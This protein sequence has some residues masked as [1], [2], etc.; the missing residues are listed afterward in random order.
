[1][2]YYSN[3]PKP[4]TVI[5][6]AKSIGKYYGTDQAK[7]IVKLDIGFWSKSI[8]SWCKQY[9][10]IKIPTYKPSTSLPV[11]LKLEIQMAFKDVSSDEP[12]SR[13]FEGITQSPSKTFNQFM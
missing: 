6:N 4:G 3:F 9:K 13:R 5:C 11:L 2:Q 8:R 7:E 1:M 10:L 12:L